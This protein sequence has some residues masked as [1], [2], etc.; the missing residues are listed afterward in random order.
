MRRALAVL[1]R[2]PAEWPL[3]DLAFRCP[4]ERHAHMLEFEHGGSC[5]AA[6][7]LDGVLVAE[8]VRPFDSVVHV[9]TP[10]VF[11]HI[12]ERR[13]DSA[14]RRHSVATRGIDLADAGGLEAGG[15]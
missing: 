15:A 9:P 6:H 4:R 14:L 11:A 13:A 2:V 5:F 7:V 1:D 3:V 8:P 12:T 10:I